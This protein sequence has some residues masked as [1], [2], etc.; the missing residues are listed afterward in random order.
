MASI[1][2][3]QLKNIKTPIGRE[4]YGCLASIYLHGK[5][6]GNYEDYGDGSCGSFYNLS[7]DAEEEIIKI[8]LEY[9]KSNPDKDWVEFYSEEEYFER[10]KENLLNRYPF[11]S[12]KDITV[13]TVYI[14]VEYLVDKFLFLQA[15]EKAF[16]KNPKRGYRAVGIKGNEVVSFSESWSNER[17]LKVANMDNLEKV[18]FEL[19]DFDIK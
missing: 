16:K 17:V 13:N 10:A 14:D 9:A 12:E 2:S 18:F 3:F 7:K 19:E 5:K 11:L 6:V 1:K 4:G 15:A 8:A